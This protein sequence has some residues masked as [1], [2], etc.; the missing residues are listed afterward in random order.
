[1]IITVRI[2]SAVYVRA[3]REGSR[4]LIADSR[5]Q[6]AGSR[7]QAADSKKQTAD[8]QTSRRAH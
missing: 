5:Q 2:W 4:Q 3:C 7:Q 8:E 1:M 6:A